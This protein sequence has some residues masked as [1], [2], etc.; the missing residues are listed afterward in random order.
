MISS[1]LQ[2][3][4]VIHLLTILV[5]DHLVPFFKHENPLRIKRGLWALNDYQDT[6]FIASIILVQI[7]DISLVL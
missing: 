5:F 6:N 7:H 4:L 3:Q 1:N 2:N